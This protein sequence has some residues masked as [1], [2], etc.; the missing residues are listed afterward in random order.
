MRVRWFFTGLIMGIVAIHAG[1]CQ[2]ASLTTNYNAFLQAYY[3]WQQEKSKSLRAYHEWQQVNSE[4]LGSGESPPPE[5]LAAFYDK[6]RELATAA[7]QWCQQEPGLWRRFWQ[8]YSQPKSTPDAGP[9]IEVKGYVSQKPTYTPEQLQALCKSLPLDPRRPDVHFSIVFKLLETALRVLP[10]E[11]E[12]VAWARQLL[13]LSLQFYQSPQLRQG[14]DRYITVDVQ[15]GPYDG[16]VLVFGLGT[17]FSYQAGLWRERAREVQIKYKDDERNPCV[18]PFEVLYSPVPLQQPLPPGEP[19][20]DHL[21]GDSLQAI[22]DARAALQRAGALPADDWLLIAGWQVWQLPKDKAFLRVRR[23][24]LYLSLR[25]LQQ[26][27]V[28]LVVESNRVV[29]WNGSYRQAVRLDGKDGFR[30][31]GEVWVRLL[32]LK[33]KGLFEV[34]ERKGY[35]WG[36]RVDVRMCGMF[37]VRPVADE[38]ESGKQ[39]GVN[40]PDVQEP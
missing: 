22:A 34:S 12:R 6:T 33:E 14:T 8:Y 21:A 32:A 23:G 26:L 11:Q 7:V 40:E 28:R 9:F 4:Q 3:E 25:A 36:E 13:E 30:E 10:S 5:L 24:E 15:A 2:S 38:S 29:L 31:R 39:E 19:D 37:A 17:D 27:Q 20:Y 16:S 35:V 1:Y 18:V